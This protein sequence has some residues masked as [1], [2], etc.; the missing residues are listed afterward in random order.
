M[1]FTTRKILQ[2]WWSLTWRTI[3]Y[4]ACLAIPFGYVSGY[5]IGYAAVKLGYHTDKIVEFVKIFNS[6]STFLFIEAPISIFSLKYSLRKHLS[7][8]IITQPQQAD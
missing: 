6:I 8:T 1:I 3:I 4:G 2:I 7:P 5:I